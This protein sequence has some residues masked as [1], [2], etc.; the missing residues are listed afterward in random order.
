VKCICNETERS[1]SFLC[2]YQEKA[3]ECLQDDR[4]G[5][6]QGRSTHGGEKS[7]YSYRKSKTGCPLWAYAL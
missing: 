6:S 1:A 4:R 2:F 5:G 7:V 3:L